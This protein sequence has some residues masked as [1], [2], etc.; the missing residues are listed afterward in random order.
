[1]KRMERGPRGPQNILEYILFDG[2]CYL[3][4]WPAAIIINF[5]FDS[6]RKQDSAQPIGKRRIKSK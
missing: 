4:V 6:V 3:F 1:M 2:F 5:Y